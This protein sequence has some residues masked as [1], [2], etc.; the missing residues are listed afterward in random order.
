[1]DFDGTDDFLNCGDANSIK[2]T[3]IFTKMAWVYIE[4][5]ATENTISAFTNQSSTQFRINTAGKIQLI[6]MN[7][8]IIGTSDTDIGTNTWAHV[9]VT[10]NSARTPKTEFS[11][12]G[13]ADGT[14][15]TTATFNNDG[16]FVFG[17]NAAG[18]PNEYMN[19]KITEY[20]EWGKILTDAQIFELGTAGV[21]R[22]ILQFPD[23][24]EFDAML[25]FD[26]CAD[27]TSCDSVVFKDLSGMGI[28]C[29]GDNGANNTG[30]TGVAEEVLTY[31]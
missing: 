15:D 31:P 13:V 26:E 28:D 5:T 7:Q 24:S 23:A 27:G 20:G 19:G 10:Y 21:K 2:N 4:G 25:P 1:M 14:T 3:T 8:A 6:D 22:H 30:L 9:T 11:L 16:D 18:T 12:N 29:T 17:Y